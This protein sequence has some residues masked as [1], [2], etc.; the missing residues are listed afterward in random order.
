MIIFT[1]LTYIGLFI[2]EGLPTTL[3]CCGIVAQVTEAFSFLAFLFLPSFKETVGR[4]GSGSGFV[5]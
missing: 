5:P 4:V 2:F 3:V 1:L